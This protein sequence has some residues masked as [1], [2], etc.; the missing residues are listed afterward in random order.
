MKFRAHNNEENKKQAVANNMVMQHKSTAYTS[1]E[2]VP[3][4]GK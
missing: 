3:G 4:H 2:F 1:I